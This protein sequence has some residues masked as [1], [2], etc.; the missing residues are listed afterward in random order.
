[1]CGM[2]VALHVVSHMAPL[3][4]SPVL[5]GTW[6]LPQLAW[7]LCYTWASRAV[8]VLDSLDQAP[9]AAHVPELLG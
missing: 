6:H 9:C 1:M 3:A 8:L 5:H 4:A 7:D 2:A